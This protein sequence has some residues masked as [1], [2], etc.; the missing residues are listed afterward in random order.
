MGWTDPHC[1]WCVGQLAVVASSYLGKSRPLVQAVC[2]TWQCTTVSGV[3]IGKGDLLLWC[4]LAVQPSSVELPQ[5]CSWAGQIPYV[6][7]YEARQHKSAVGSLVG[8]IG[9]CATWLCTIALGV[10][11]GGEGPQGNRLEEGFQN[12]ACQ[13]LCRDS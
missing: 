12:G 13:H 9:P 2:V 4:G 3:L 1:S 7:G 6:A 10:L 8:G 5:V 11:V